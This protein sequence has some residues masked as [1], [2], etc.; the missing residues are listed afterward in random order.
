MTK[1]SFRRNAV[2]VAVLAGAALGSS[3]LA[4]AA[5]AMPGADAGMMT[6]HKTPTKD[7]V[8]FFQKAA[9]SGMT[10]IAA[11]KIAIAK[12]SD[13]E[14]KNFAQKMIKDHGKADAELM[15]LATKKGITLPAAL[16][17][18]HQARLDDL[19]KES[20]KDFDDEYS[21][22]MSSA[23]EDAVDL[24][25]ETAK[26]SKDVDVKMFAT[27]TLPTLKVHK[28]MADQLDADH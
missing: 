10:E 5:D 13:P 20:G 3:G 28:T 25:T 7:D 16:D 1:R 22:M 18:E 2:A 6:A 15:A 21:D 9:L 17:K 19:N 8:E 4:A 24:F 27:E 14:V 12:S 11:A 26:D 23:H